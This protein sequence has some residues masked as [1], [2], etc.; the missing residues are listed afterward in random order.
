MQ[1]GNLTVSWNRKTLAISEGSDLILVV[2]TYLE[3]VFALDWL[4]T[5]PPQYLAPYV[6]C[7]DLD[8]GRE[9]ARVTCRQ[10]W[11]D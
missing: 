7:G 2:R 11:G 6:V 4:A 3:G 5:H 9:I 1:L 10:K 8:A